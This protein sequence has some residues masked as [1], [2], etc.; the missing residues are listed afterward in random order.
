M[1]QAISNSKTSKTNIYAHDVLQNYS[2][3]RTTNRI[4][5]KGINVAKVGKEITG[6]SGLKLTKKALKFME[7]LGNSLKE[8]FRKIKGNDELPFVD[9][10]LIAASESAREKN[11][12]ELL[13]KASHVGDSWLSMKMQQ[14][15]RTYGAYPPKSYLEDLV[16][17][18]SASPD[19]KEK[20]M[21]KI[22]F[23]GRPHDAMSDE[24]SK[25]EHSPWLTPG[26]K[27]QEIRDIELK[28]HHEAGTLDADSIHHHEEDSSSPTFLGN[29]SQ[30]E[31]KGFLGK[32]FDSLLGNNHGSGNKDMNGHHLHT[33]DVS[34]TDTPDDFT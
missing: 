15:I 3:P 17:Q 31:H 20:L 34:G 27:A 18:S 29:S 32:L 10:P 28:Y 24:I 5:F 23:L 19:D 30:A 13:D 33:D 7:E 25:I 1:I 8:V 6:E 4:S 11:I 9:K 16:K 21:H 12:Q 2:N 22:S 26:E 14:Y